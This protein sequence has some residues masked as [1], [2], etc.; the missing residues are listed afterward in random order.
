ML[1]VG[2]VLVG[3]WFG[4]MLGWGEIFRG[5]LREVLGSMWFLPGLRGEYI[6]YFSIQAGH[7]VVR[8][9]DAGWGEVFSGQGMKIILCGTGASLQWWQ[10]NSLRLFLFTFFLWGWGAYLIF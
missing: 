2:L 3:G 6:S 4:L 8:V 9:L 10:D 5:G 1:G 7:P